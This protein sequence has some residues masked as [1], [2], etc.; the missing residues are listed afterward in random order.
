M[1]DWSEVFFPLELFQLK[2]QK[3]LLSRNKTPDT[4][5]RRESTTALRSARPIGFCKIKPGS[6]TPPASLISSSSWPLIKRIGTSIPNSLIL[7]ARLTPFIPGSDISVAK[8]TIDLLLCIT[9]NADSAS[10]CAE[11]SKPI[12][13]RMVSP[14]LRSVSSS[15]TKIT[16][17]RLNCSPGGRG[18]RISM[19]VPL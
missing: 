8:S 4:Y 11:T 16:R 7:C 10:P 6:G 9:S 18:H 13:E 17:P 3:T 1:H 19:K 14:N 12:L 2:M 15:S 5:E